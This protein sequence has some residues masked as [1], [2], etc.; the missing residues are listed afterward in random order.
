[1]SKAYKAVLF[2]LDGT[3]IDTSSGILK[4]L[5]YLIETMNLPPVEPENKYKFIGPPLDESYSKYLG[6]EGKRLA[7]AIDIYR[8]YCRDKGYKDYEYYPGMDELLD[9]LNENDYKTFIVTMKENNLSKKVIQATKY[10]SKFTDI[11]GNVDIGSKTKSELIEEVLEKYNLKKDEVLFIGDTYIDAN[12][13]KEAGVDYFPAMFGFGYS[14]GD[15]L[16]VD[17]PYV[18][19][20]YNPIDLIKYL[21]QKEGI[22]ATC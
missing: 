1:M 8:F 10:D 16:S 9:W 7:E 13:A 21:N 6:L 12:G 20:L 4:G 18:K 11:I 17:T 2:D 14:H 3:T 5:D 15:E 22:D 19:K